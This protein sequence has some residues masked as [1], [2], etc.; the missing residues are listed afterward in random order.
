MRAALAVL[1]VGTF[2]QAE[3]PKLPEPYRSLVDLAQTT[4]P[5]FTADALLRIAESGKIDDRDAVRDLVEQA[6][7]L[8]GSAAF[9]VRMRALPGTTTDTRSGILNQAYDLKLDALSLESRAVRD[10]LAIDKAKARDLLREISPPTLAPLTCDDALV[11]DVADF[12]R[13]IGM[14]ANAAFS[15]KERA[16][17]ENVNLILDYLGQA[18]SPAQLAPLARLVRNANVTPPQRELLWSRFNG[19]LE[20]IPGDERSYS[21]SLSSMSAESGPE[22]EVSLEKYK[23][24]GSTCKGDAS[25]A[26]TTTASTPKLERFWQTPKSKKLL[27]D[28]LKLRLA[29]DGRLFTDVERSTREWQEQLTG[30]L[31]ELADWTAGEEPSA[32]VYYHQ[33]C[34]VFEALIELIPAG[35]QRD[36]ALLDYVNFV[37]NPDLQRQSPVEWFI[38]AHSVLE[39]VRHAED[40]T[41]GKLGDAYQHSGNTVLTLEIALEKSLG[42]RPPAMTAAEN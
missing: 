18:S 20:N 30:Y 36:K 35:P 15:E 25:S 31:S 29:S 40:A 16:R 38:E 23:R 4:P 26:T 14:V 37:G 32:T 13:T 11:Y 17:E 28:G 3:Q 41:L 19:L 27:E 10:I 7:R 34:L 2:L 33:K 1:A 12:Y 21:A 8:A 22:M 39:R 42:A 24:S 6:F 9:R 5:E